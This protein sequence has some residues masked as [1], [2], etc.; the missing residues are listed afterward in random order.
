MF[1]ALRKHITPATILAFVA[2][3]FAITGGA[4][5]ASS[6]GGSSGAKPTAST[7]LASAAKAKP[8]AKAGPRGPAGPKGATGAT[9]P[10]GAT[11]ATGAI[12]ATGP[13][14]PQGAA[15][16][17]GNTGE[18]GSPGKNG[19]NGASVASTAIAA[20]PANTECKEGGSEFTAG[21]AKTFACN[22]EKGVLHP[23]ETLPV[24]A[25]ETGAFSASGKQ[26]P[27]ANF[28]IEALPI[29]ISFTIRLATALSSTLK[30]HLIGAGEGA[31]QGKENAAIVAKECTGTEAEPGAASGNLCIFFTDEENIE[32][33]GSLS[34]TAGGSGEGVSTT[35]AILLLHAETGTAAMQAWGTWAVT[36]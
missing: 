10:T 12:G 14:G 16:A 3:V 6:P 34:L 1:K 2:L 28:G 15:G 26:V 17:T 27:I 35:G 21:K 22:G 19:A 4:F 23:G 30:V 11:G 25:T 36:G 32:I 18:T 13:G 31:G 20:N 9:G 7:T 5:A 24:G 29:P 8:K 33:S